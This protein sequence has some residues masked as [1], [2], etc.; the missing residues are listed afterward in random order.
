MRGSL[1][2]I[3]SS[4][5]GYSRLEWVAVCTVMLLWSSVVALALRPVRCPVDAAGYSIYSVLRV[6]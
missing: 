6:V 1:V 4:L 3:G 5:V 2:S